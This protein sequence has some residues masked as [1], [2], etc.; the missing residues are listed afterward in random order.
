MDVADWLQA[1]PTVD[2][3]KFLRGDT[4]KLALTSEQFSQTFYESERGKCILASVGE[5]TKFQDAETKNYIHYIGE[6][7]RNSHLAALKLLVQRE[8]LLWWR[9]KTQIQARLAQGECSRGD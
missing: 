9:D 4:E 1:L 2:G 3:S 7:Y 5:E 8:M 6:R